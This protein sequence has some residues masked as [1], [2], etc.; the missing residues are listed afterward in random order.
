MPASRLLR[1]VVIVFSAALLFAVATPLTF[2]ANCT[3]PYIV[4]EGETWRYITL[5]VFPCG[6]L[7]TDLRAAN[8]GVGD[9]LTA[10]D[11]LIIPGVPTS[12]PTVTV[13]NTPTATATATNTPTPRPTATPTPTPTRRSAVVPSSAQLRPS[14]QGRFSAE[15]MP[16][17]TNEDSLIAWNPDTRQ[18]IDH[19]VYGNGDLN[20]SFQAG[21]NE[22]GILI[23]VS[24]MDAVQ[25]TPA[26][27]SEN[28]YNDSIEIL[29]DTDLYG[30]FASPTNDGDDYQ[31]VVDINGNARLYYPSNQTVKIE[32]HFLRRNDQYIGKLL[33][34]WELLGINWEV[35]EQNMIFGFSL[36]V[37]DNDTNGRVQQ[38][39]FATS[40]ARISEKNPTRWGTLTLGGYAARIG[41]SSNPV[42]ANPTPRTP[43]V[44][45]GWST[46]LTSRLHKGVTAQIVYDPPLPNTVYSQPTSNSASVDSL[47]AGELATMLDGPVCADG[48]VWWW[49]QYWTGENLKR[50]WTSEG[51]INQ[52]WM[53]PIDAPGGAWVDP[54]PYIGAMVFCEEKDLA[55]ADDCSRGLTTFT[56]NIEE[57]YATWDA[58]GIPAGSTMYRRYTFR[59]KD[60]TRRDWRFPL[61]EDEV[62]SSRIE[63]K[64]M[65]MFFD[66][67]TG[68]VYSNGTHMK[69][70]TYKVELILN[71]LVV[72]S[73]T[74]TIQ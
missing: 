2:A 36:A 23:G 60:G 3:S 15:Y 74:F 11:V 8:P 5:I 37:S 49:V 53:E 57:I 65:K 56:G 61:S 14:N 42:V 29:L 51:T 6:V 27:I 52:Y 26:P 21:W 47:V 69:P 33:I 7:Y 9:V 73:G 20:A 16:Y 59:G 39:V 28:F 70:G 19:L 1:M 17:L 31:I 41:G 25:R 71:G 68:T 45:G 55:T 64:P 4:R 54:N 66:A 35:V 67:K 30:D 62:I 38:R 44:Q 40:P 48:K 72:Q 43:T 24:V 63:H 12:T 18:P 58:I 10:G 46:C 32:S 22:Y 13:T 50:G 34:P